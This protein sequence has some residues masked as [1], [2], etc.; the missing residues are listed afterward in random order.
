MLNSTI[1]RHMG[2]TDM[3]VV[4]SNMGVVDKTDKALMRYQ[5]IHLKSLRKRCTKKPKNGLRPYIEHSLPIHSSL[6]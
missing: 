4:G 6:H 3:D 5:V 2:K 1:R